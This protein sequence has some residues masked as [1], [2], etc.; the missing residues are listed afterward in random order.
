M[1]SWKVLRRFFLIVVSSSDVGLC[2]DLPVAFSEFYPPPGHGS[3]A[4]KLRLGPLNRESYARQVRTP[5]LPNLIP[6]S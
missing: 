1:G 6:K 2:K 5:E 4:A 3:D